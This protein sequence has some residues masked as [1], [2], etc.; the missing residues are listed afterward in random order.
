M[1]VGSRVPKTMVGGSMIATGT[2]PGEMEER[3][4][5]LPEYMAGH[6]VVI[7]NNDKKG[8]IDYIDLSYVSPYAFVLDPVRAALEVYGQQGM[9]DK[10]QV[11]RIGAGALTALRMFAEPFGEESLIYERLADVLPSQDVPFVSVFGRGGRNQD[12]VPIYNSTD[13]LGDKVDK[14]LG[15]LM[16]GII[17]EYAK[18][19]AEADRPLSVTTPREMLNQGRVLRAITETPG[20]R[21]EEYNI[22]KEG[23]RLVT[24]FT[25]MTYDVKNDFAFAGKA[26]TPRRTEAKSAATRDM[27]RANLTQ[28]DM[29]RSWDTYLDSLYREQSTMDKERKE[30]TELRKWSTH[31]RNEKRRRKTRGNGAQ[32]GKEEENAIMN[33]EFWPTDASKELWR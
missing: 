15:H 8:K 29:L 16:N 17:P 4:E 19:I 23:A 32:G 26:D 27:K 14:S 13:S 11:E 2:A 31:A 28:E 3:R 22:F 6:D 12:G 33:G 10:S 20:N 21:G 7:L 9:L 18:L 24:G 1:A 25:P 5:Q 30:E